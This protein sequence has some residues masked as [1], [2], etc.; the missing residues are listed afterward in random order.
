MKFLKRITGQSSQQQSA[1][2]AVTCNYSNNY[3][4]DQV[5]TLTQPK[6]KSS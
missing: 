5:C 6:K 3:Y 1:Q 4:G 2:T